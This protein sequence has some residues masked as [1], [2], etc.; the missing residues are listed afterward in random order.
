MMEVRVRHVSKH[1]VKDID[2]IARK[3]G[4]SRQK[5]L[6]V[7]LNMLGKSRV[8]IDNEKNIEGI[9]EGLEKGIQLI[10]YRTKNLNKGI[11][12]LSDV[13]MFSHGITKKDVDDLR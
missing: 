5:F 13:L 11:E 12:K 1:L 3:R 9:I 6:L 8:L 2:H 7:Y 10:D 4:I